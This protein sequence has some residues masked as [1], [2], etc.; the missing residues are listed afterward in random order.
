MSTQAAMDGKEYA[1][2]Q[3]SQ[4][5]PNKVNSDY[6]FLEG[7]N[8]HQILFP[9]LATSRLAADS[10]KA[11]VEHASSLGFGTQACE[12][13]IYMHLNRTHTACRTLLH[14]FNAAVSA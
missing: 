13:H 1:V 5:T 9:K 12:L 10:H 4:Y 7:Y 8:S 6:T 11:F 14:S 2:S 3:Y